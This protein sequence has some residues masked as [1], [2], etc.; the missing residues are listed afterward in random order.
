MR[1]RGLSRKSARWGKEFIVDTTPAPLPRK[2]G[3]LVAV[4]LRNCWWSAS[5]F[6]IVPQD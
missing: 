4:L 5:S 1:N 2:I 6:D 3:P